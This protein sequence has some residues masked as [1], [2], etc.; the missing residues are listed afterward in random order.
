MKK[1]KL[2]FVLGTRPEA[3]KLGPLIRMAKADSRFWVKV[4]STG[5]HREMLKPVF[6][7]FEITPD[8]DFD[9]MK[10]GQTLTGV[11]TGILENM[12]SLLVGDRPDWVLVQGDTTTTMAGALSAFY[13]KIPVAHIEA[14]LRTGDISSPFPEELNRRVTGLIADLHFPPTAETEAFLKAEGVPANR[15]L[16]VGNTGIDAL[17]GTR[18]AILNRPSLKEEMEKEFPFLDSKKKLILVTVHR[19]ESFGEPMKK[20]LKAI[21]ELSRRDDVEFLIPLHMNP[22]VRKVASEVLTDAR[23]V[24]SDS[25]PGSSRIW[26]TEPQ[27]YLKFVYLM[28][29][30][31]FIIS[32]SGGVQEEAPSLGKPVLV[33]RETTERPE[34]I[35]AGTSRLV[36]SET[37]VIL[38]ECRRLLDQPSE[39]AKMAEAKNPFGDGRACARILDRLALEADR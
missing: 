32:D 3:V 16:Q 31:H 5:Q 10:P 27:D 15:I 14:G 30:C 35:K 11:T 28:M 22:E 24:T 17:L 4:C 37:D 1:Q 2:L 39:Y 12:R 19:R 36:G 26:L 23:W 8:A 7:L 21:T 9:L 34:A 25:T 13:E 38:T 20:I 33:V 18:E 6:K 29:K